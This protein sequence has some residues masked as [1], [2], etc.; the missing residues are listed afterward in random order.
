MNVPRPGHR[1]PAAVLTA[2][3]LAAVATGCDTSGGGSAGRTVS[4]SAASPS[5]EGSRVVA[6]ED[7]YVYDDGLRVKVSRPKPFRP[8]GT[9]VGHKAENS[10]VTFTVTL[11]N[12]TGQPFEVT[13]VLVN[14]KAGNGGARVDQIFD[15][16]RGVGNPLTGSLAADESSKAVF[17]VDVPTADTGKIDVEVRP[18]F[19]VRYNTVH[20]IGSAR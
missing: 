12:G 10:P 7:T 9:A 2:G 19:G 18:D 17:A 20:W 11:T 1:A 8:S 14:V 6:F 15:S 13:G 3:L 5:S 16:A 4:P